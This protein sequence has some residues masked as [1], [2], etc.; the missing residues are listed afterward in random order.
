MRT[1]L[2]RISV[3]AV[4]R[5]VAR[6]GDRRG[7][8]RHA[9]R[10]MTPV[11]QLPNPTWFVGCGNMGGAIL[12]GWRV[13]GLDLGAVTVVRPSGAPVE[14][15]RTVRD[16]AEAGPPPE[17]VVLAFKP[18]KLDEIAPNLRRYLGARTVLVSLLA[19]AEAVSLRQRFPGVA[20]VVRAM[21]NLP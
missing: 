11:L 1:F 8:H 16:L 2:P 12:D 14:G 3:R 7:P 9:R 18:Q 13:G 19:G 4:G 20:T 6:R 17:L 5:Q 10:S 15:A 21:P